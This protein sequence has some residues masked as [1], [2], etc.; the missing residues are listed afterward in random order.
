MRAKLET[1]NTLLVILNLV[2]VQAWNHVV[3]ANGIPE[4]DL[5]FYGFITNNHFQDRL[6]DDILHWVVEGAGQS[7]LARSTMV[8]VN[9]QLFYFVRIPC[10]TLE[11]DEFN[12]TP[13][14]NAMPLTSSPASFTR[15]ATVNGKVVKFLGPATTTFNFSK[16]DRGRMERIDLQ[17]SSTGDSNTDSDGDGISDWAEQIAGTDP[18]SEQS[19]FKASSDIQPNPGGGL[20]IRWSSVPGKVYSVS[21]ATELIQ[22]FTVLAPEIPS[23]GEVTS[24]TDS[25]ARGSGPYFYR[26]QVKTRQ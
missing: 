4:P 1:I 5:I 15:S 18:R 3:L 25:S 6:S 14:A 13:S 16:A 19:V 8:R 21:R 17:V 2:P 20:I 11:S 22:G 26:I 23:T 10:E 7:A 9:Q 24:F 12:L